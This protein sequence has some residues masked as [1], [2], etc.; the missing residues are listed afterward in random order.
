MEGLSIK[1]IAQIA[2]INE[3][4]VKSR[5]FYATKQ[6]AKLLKEYK[7]LT[8]IMEDKSISILRQNP[9]NRSAKRKKSIRNGVKPKKNLMP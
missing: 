3:G 7:T 9:L 1:E 5:I 2:Q 4:T 8:L 6:L